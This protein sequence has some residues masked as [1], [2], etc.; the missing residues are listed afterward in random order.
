MITCNQNTYGLFQK[1]KAS[2]NG[3]L[4]CFVKKAA[5]EKNVFGNINEICQK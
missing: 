5:F 2:E 3:M 1:D 4:R